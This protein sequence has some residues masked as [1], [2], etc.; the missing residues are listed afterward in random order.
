MNRRGETRNQKSETTNGKPQHA[1]PDSWEPEPVQYIRTY[2]ENGYTIYVC[3]PR[4][5]RGYKPL[6]PLGDV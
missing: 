6:K 3:P 5:A 1:S 2:E 4:Y